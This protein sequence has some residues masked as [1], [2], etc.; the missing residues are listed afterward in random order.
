[1][2]ERLKKHCIVWTLGLAVV[3]GP[4]LRVRAQQADSKTTAQEKQQEPANDAD[5][6]IVGPDEGKK[7]KAQTI[8]DAWTLL[9][10]AVGDDK[11]VTIRIQGLA[12]LGSMGVNTRGAKMIADAF[13]DKDVDV[14]TAAVLAAGQTRDRVLIPGIRKL[15]DDKEPQVAFVAATT[16]WRLGDHSGESLL[17][18]VVNGDRKANASLMHGGMHQA[19]RE[20]HDPA[21]MARL[22]AV[23]GASMLLGPFGF[24][25]TA[26]EYVKKNGG[27]SARVLAIEEISQNRTA[28]VRSTLLDALTDKDLAVRA[29]AA[30][31]LRVNHDAEVQKA[32]ANLF[33]DPKRPVQLA[34]ASS[35][36]ISAGVVAVPRT[37]LPTP[38]EIH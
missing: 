2:P 30:K 5:S 10:D 20:M 33:G 8:D 35:Y 7:T 23:E 38:A 19:S 3:G 13:D 14:R 29:A 4:A 27:D 9:S 26:Y 36:L 1:M 32:L 22:G 25:V 18:D 21:A 11:H 17:V 12:A 31:A 34:A 6:K 15:L 37:E 16:L 28:D 24:G